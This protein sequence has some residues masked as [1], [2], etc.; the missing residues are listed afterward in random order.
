MYQPKQI[1]VTKTFV[2]FHIDVDER[3][4]VARDLTDAI[5]VVDQWIATNYPERSGCDDR[6]TVSVEDE[7]IVIT[8]AA[9]AT[10]TGSKP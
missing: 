5:R 3:P 8:V 7:S 1:T 6:F 4:A 10:Y 2:Q 9:S